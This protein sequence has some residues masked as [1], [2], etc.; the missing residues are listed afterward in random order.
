MITVD[1]AAALCSSEQHKSLTK[2]LSTQFLLFFLI[3]SIER[4][5]HASMDINCSNEFRRGLFCSASST[6]LYDGGGG[7]DSGGFSD[8]Q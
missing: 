7:G 5:V 2:R 6:S 3:N 1:A 4:E 8:R